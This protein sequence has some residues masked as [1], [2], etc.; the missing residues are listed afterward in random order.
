ME[1]TAMKKLVL[2]TV[3]GYIALMATNYLV[4]SVLLM[5]DYAAIPGS[6]RTPEGMMH[7]FWAMLIGQFFFA[8]LFAYIYQR[9]AEAKPWLPQGIRYAV[10]VTFLTVVPYSLSDYVVYIVP[11]QLVIKWMIAGAIQLAIMGVIV[12]GIYQNPRA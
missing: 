4:H 9:G 8:A 12:A 2:A 3:A 1:V 6:H 5:S 7:R 11:Y 10:L